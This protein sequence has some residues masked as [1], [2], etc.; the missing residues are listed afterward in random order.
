MRKEEWIK[1]GIF[2]VV[3]GDALGVPVEFTSRS[4]RKMDP[5]TGM[6]AYGTHNQPKGTWSDDSSMMLATLDSLIKRNGPDY[7]DIMECFYRWR[8]FGEYTPFGEVFDIGITCSK[9]IANY[10]SGCDPLMCGGDRENDNGNGSLM[11]IMPVSLYVSLKNENWE[12]SMPETMEIICNS[13]DLTHRHIRSRIGC[14]LYTFICHR[15]ISRENSHLEQI[16]SDAFYEVAEYFAGNIPF[17]DELEKYGILKDADNLKNLPEDRIKSGGYVVDTLVS[18]VWCL[19][20]SASF[21]ECVLKAVNLGDDT[22]TVGAVAG[23]LAGLWYGYQNIPRE[24]INV[25]AKKEWIF[26]LCEKFGKI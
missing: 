13:S 25:I 7:K 23:G 2:G 11:R 9:A 24:W 20:N 17:S 3:V 5:V 4:E 26:E 12:N 10:T 21:R 14:V 8:S 18:S 1:S 19:L 22:D 16:I 6:R 15:M